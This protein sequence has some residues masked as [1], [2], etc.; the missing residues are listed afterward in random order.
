MEMAGDIEGKR[1]E[2]IEQFKG[3]MTKSEAALLRNQKKELELKLEKKINHVSEM[4][5]RLKRL[6]EETVKRAKA[7]LKIVE[8]KETLWNKVQKL[9]AGVDSFRKKRM[10]YSEEMKSKI[11]E[12]DHLR[13]ETG[14]IEDKNKKLDNQVKEQ[15]DVIHR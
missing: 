6:E 9:E 5:M 13:E 8:E 7:E 12:N 3:L 11:T 14:K 4:Q 2:D 10:E 1:N 15:E